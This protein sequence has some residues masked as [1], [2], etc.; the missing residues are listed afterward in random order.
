MND[1]SGFKSEKSLHHQGVAGLCRILIE[2]D[3]V[4]NGVKLFRKYIDIQHLQRPQE[5]VLNE[6]LTRIRTAN[7][8]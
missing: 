5:V 2:A 7:P 6:S 8:T 3:V 4:D 1:L